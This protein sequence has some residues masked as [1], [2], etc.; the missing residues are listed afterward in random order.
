MPEAFGSTCQTIV[1]LV[2]VGYWAY[3][4]YGDILEGGHLGSEDDDLGVVL[5]Q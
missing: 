5:D 1:F 3:S 4:N 2:V